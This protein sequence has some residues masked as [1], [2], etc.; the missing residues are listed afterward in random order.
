MVDCGNNFSPDFETIIG[1]SKEYIYIGPLNKEGQVVER[2]CN[3]LDLYQNCRLYLDGLSRMSKLII[4]FYTLGHLSRV[5]TKYNI[6]YI[7]TNVSIS[8]SSSRNDFY[9]LLLF[10]IKFSY[11]LDVLDDDF[12]KK[13]F[14]RII[15]W[16][17]LNIKKIIDE[18]I[19]ILSS[20]N[21]DEDDFPFTDNDT[22]TLETLKI[23]NLD[24]KN[25]IINMHINKKNNYDND[26]DNRDNTIYALIFYLLDCYYEIH[27]DQGEYLKQLDRDL[28]AIV[29]NAP[30]INRCIRLYRS[31][32]NY[33]S[34]KVGDKIKLNTITSTTCSQQSNIGIFSPDGN[35]CIGEFIIKPNTKALFLNYDETAYGKAMYEVLLPKGIEFELIKIEKGKNI[36]ALEENESIINEDIIQNIQPFKDIKY[37]NPD[38]NSLRKKDIY[39]FKSI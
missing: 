8:N 37:E 16:I 15:N 1:N 32:S 26:D 23:E 20:E 9:K 21:Y 6:G 29:N 38:E 27:L 33:K 3:M 19:Q 10:L 13:Y 14:D 11:K 2:D 18:I 4:L 31:A 30:I 22:E 35:C 12:Y 24:I 17:N 36:V 7:K 25:M 28:D 34:Y 39:L 5:I